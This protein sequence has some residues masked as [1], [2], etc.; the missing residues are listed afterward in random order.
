MLELTRRSL[1]FGA[2]GFALSSVAK[3]ALREVDLKLVLAVDVS[4]SVIE[5][6]WQIQKRGYAHALQSQKVRN[7]ILGGPLGAI[8]VT[9]IQWS[10]RHEQSQVVPWTLLNTPDAIDKLSSTIGRMERQFSNG[11]AVGAALECSAR[12][13]AEAPFQSMHS[14]IDISGDGFDHDPVVRREKTVPLATIRDEIVGQ[15]ITINALP[16]LGDR[17]A[18]PYGTYTNVAEMYEAE[19]IGGPGNF[20]VVVENPDRADLF[21]ECLINKL[22]LEIA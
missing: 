10:S 5:D 21:I 12:L 18:V 14:V 13:I 17:I 20:M 2:A 6:R 15:G 8:A 3:A 4:G 19:A 22:H 7:N 16:L 9:L 11:T 1:L